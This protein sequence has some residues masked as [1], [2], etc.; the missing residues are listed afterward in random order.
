MSVSEETLSVE[1]DIADTI[2]VV[3]LLFTKKGLASLGV[4]LFLF[5]GGTSFLGT[6]LSTMMGPSQTVEVSSPDLYRLVEEEMEPV[7]EAVD[8]NT[9]E[10]AIQSIQLFAIE[11]KQDAISVSLQETTR[12]LNRLAGQMELVVQMELR[13][14]GRIS[15]P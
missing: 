8:Q 15:I 1:K 2:K 7:Q 11:E 10:L 14:S 9:N 4:L 6:N 3:R 12:V 5:G 13:R